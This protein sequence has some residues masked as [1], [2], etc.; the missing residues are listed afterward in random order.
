MELRS[1]RIHLPMSTAV[2]HW[3]DNAVALEHGPL[4]YALPIKERW[5]PMIEPKWSTADFPSWNAEPISAWNYGLAID[6]KKVADQVHFQRKAMT[7]DPWVDPPVML[8]TP[9]QLIESWKLAAAPAK[10]HT[11]AASLQHFTPP[12]PPAYARHTA[13]PVEQVTLVPYGSTHLRVTIF[14]ML[15]GGS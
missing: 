11:A 1:I 5:T 10:L 6:S 14:P 2:S 15:G 7:P 13:A 3:P 12:L 4:V 8:V 9:A